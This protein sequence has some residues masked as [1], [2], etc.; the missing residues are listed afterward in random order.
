MI[1]TLCRIDGYQAGVATSLFLCSHDDPRLC[2]LDGETWWPAIARLPVLRYDFFD[3]SFGGDIIAPTGEMQVHIGAVPG[4]P[5][6]SLHDARVRLWR[7]P[8][9]GA[10][11]DFILRFDGRVKD[12]PS[13]SD[14]MAAISI[15]VDDVWLDEPL[16]RTY[17]G[18]GGAEG[19]ED[20]KGTVKPLIFGVMR[21]VSATLI[22]P[23][24]N[25]YQINDGPINGADTAMDRLVRF[26]LP[27][28]NHAS[29]AALK[30]ATVPSG[31]WATALAGGYVRMGA[32]PDG[33]LTFHARG[34]NGGAGGWVRKAGAIIG[35]IAEIRGASARV[36]AASLL[37]LDAAC[38][39]NLT[40]AVREQTTARDVILSVAQSINA[41]PVIDWLGQLHV[42]PVRI[43]AA[44]GVLA[45]DGSALPPVASVEQMAVSAPYWRLAQ[46]AVLTQT[47]HNASDIQSLDPQNERGE[48][49][50]EESYYRGNIVNLAD[51]SRWLC[52]V[53]GPITGS[54]PADGN[55][56]WT[57][58]AGPV[59]ADWDLVTGPGKPEDNATNGANQ[60]EKDQIAEAERIS[61]E[62]MTAADEARDAAEA[63]KN[64][65]IANATEIEEIRED[66][67]A[68]GAVVSENWLA[69]NS[70]TGSLAR[71]RQEVAAGGA[72]NMFDNAALAIG[73]Q[74]WDNWTNQPN[75]TFGRNLPE[76]DDW[77]IEG[78]N[79]LAIHQSGRTGTD[80]AADWR[81]TVSVEALAWYDFSALLA[82]HNT[83]GRFII[84]WVDSA[85]NEL[86]GRTVTDWMALSTGGRNRDGWNPRRGVKAQ[87]PAG[88]VKAVAVIRKSDTNEG[89][90]DSWM[91]A[92]EPQF[93]KVSEDSSSPQP[94][95]TGTDLAASSIQQ[96]ALS[97]LGVD[98]A[99]LE[100]AVQA[101]GNP[102]LI[103]NGNF[104]NGLDGYWI[105]Q[106]SW[107]L[108]DSNENG[109][110]LYC[111]ASDLVQFMSERF[112]ATSVGTNIT[113]SAS[114]TCNAIDIAQTYV[115]IR[116]EDVDG[117]TTGWSPGGLVGA[118]HKPFDTNRT[119]TTGTIPPNTRYGRFFF[120]GRPENGQTGQHIA[121]QQIKAE[122]GSVV[123][124]YNNN[125]AVTQSFKAIRTQET[126][127]SQ[128]DTN[129]NARVDDAEARV[130]ENR[131]AIATT[132]GKLLGKYG[133]EIAAGTGLARFSG[134]AGQ[135]F[136]G[137]KFEADYFGIGSGGQTPFEIIGGTVYIKNAIIKDAAII[138]SKIEGQSVSRAVYS[139]TLTVPM[140]GT[141]GLWI[142]LVDMTLADVLAGSRIVFQAGLPIQSPRDIG[143]IFRLVKYVNGVVVSY[144][145]EERIGQ[146]A[147]TDLAQQALS[148]VG[149]SRG[150]AEAGTHRYVLQA[151]RYA[152]KDNSSQK[153]QTFSAM[154]KEERR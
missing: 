21:Y 69:L 55:A 4:L 32:A 25:I 143:V 75:V 112:D 104:E 153:I 51:G 8:L 127:M 45:S 3:G 5:A 100:F 16:L 150:S 30:A 141:I 46:Q 124:T 40:V 11:S 89:A 34:D 152:Y 149:W 19:P 33:L 43:G 142:D 134:F 118:Q 151:N 64:D 147:G 114:I 41:V 26:S 81:Q 103:P 111:W 139:D 91:W 130:D 73:T 38:P 109:R 36:N 122:R 62:A 53:D 23:V 63:A 12:Q 87:A 77:H 20:I 72:G 145:Y 135:G 83:L 108:A 125:A 154:L 90:A 29:F 137:W 48:Y 138:T 50:P 61:A 146:A 113:V 54:A 76:G 95:S 136:S 105:F 126:A 148:Y 6:L 92:S 99:A 49:D 67:T 88:A 106:G 9:G 80:S 68:Q 10:W 102:N 71:L 119:F 98:M 28:A 37:A 93:K 17:A 129:L 15:G 1:A 60:E 59:E 31:R 18:T 131:T 24:D 96:E 14:G 42:L 66:L 133:L 116:F 82:A 52:A 70:P 74:G 107:A 39:W 44:G 27:M 2:H 94:Y 47:V 22:D 117:N 58:L 123:T 85:G 120:N 56:D 121:I 57:R 86:P 65:V 13:V 101:G 115:Q 97:A 79:A 7:G 78:V 128:M 35:R 140:I 110:Y 84:L 144:P 132:D